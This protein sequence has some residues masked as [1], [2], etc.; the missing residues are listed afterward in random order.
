MEKNWCNYRQKQCI[1]P[2]KLHFLQNICFVRS[3]FS[4]PTRLF[5]SLPTYF[6]LTLIIM[7]RHYT[8]SMYIKSYKS[9]SIHTVSSS[10]LVLSMCLI[11]VQELVSLKFSSI[12]PGAEP[13]HKLA[14]FQSLLFSVVHLIRSMANLLFWQKP[15]M[16]P[17]ICILLRL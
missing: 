9:T 12:S 2:V 3:D 7:F 13:A 10:K 1:F 17:Y 8:H 11:V 4:P 6:V 5:Y 15:A 14:K 16:L